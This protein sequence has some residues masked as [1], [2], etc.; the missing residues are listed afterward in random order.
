MSSP[1]VFLDR[2]N[3]LIANDGDLGEP[4]GV[5]LL[6][7]VAAGLARLREAGFRLVVVSN[8]SGVARGVFTEDDVAAVNRRIAEVA[9]DLIDRFYHCPH[10]DQGTV[11]S[12][13]RSCPWRKP[14][15]GMLLRAAKDLDLDLGRS[16]MVG[17]QPR[18]VEAGARAGCRTVLVSTDEQADATARVA[19]F[20]EA[21]EFICQDMGE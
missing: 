15:P 5:V 18:D 10:H 19:T 12:Y 6:E 21:V 20:T 11:E 13:T 8:Q 16:W 3:T 17:D 9:D 2:D 1:A 7:G 14:N 4:A